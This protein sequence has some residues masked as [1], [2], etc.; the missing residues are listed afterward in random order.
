MFATGTPL[1]LQ[2]A[3]RGHHEPDDLFVDLHQPLNLTLPVHAFNS[4][5]TLGTV[6]LDPKV[7]GQPVRRDIV[8]RVVKWQLAKRRQGT[9]KQKN[10]SEVSGSGKKP[11]AQKG[12]GRARAGHR[13]PPHWRSG[14]RAFPKVPRDYSYKLQKKVRNQ[15]LRSVLSAKILEGAVHIVD[16]DTMESHKTGPLVEWLA[17]RNVDSAVI[18]DDDFEE[19]D[20]LSMATN[21]IPRVLLLPQQGVNVYDIMKRRDLILTKKGLEMLTE[22]VL[23]TGRPAGKK[24]A[25]YSGK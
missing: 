15:G 25:N 18:V 9:H 21:N 5:E 7:F 24:T 19:S 2:G 4:T 6:T 3:V 20:M 23:T 1:D 12:T 13:R 8:Q 10:I 22:R 11:W 14:A 17:E 16:G